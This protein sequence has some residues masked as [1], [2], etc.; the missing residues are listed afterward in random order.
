[1]SNLLRMLTNPQDGVTSIRY[2]AYSTV[3]VLLS[4]LADARPRSAIT[5]S[6]LPT[7]L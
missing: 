5:D 4:V 6:N 2:I 7:V 3:G 1:M